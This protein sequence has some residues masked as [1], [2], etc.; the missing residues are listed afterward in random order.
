LPTLAQQ[1]HR[2]AQRLAMQTTQ[3]AACN[4]L[5]EVEERL[6][7][8]ILMTHDRVPSD[9]LPLTQE[10]MAQMLGSRRASVTIAAGLLQKGGLISY[11][12][13]SVRIL[14]RRKLEQASCE[15][16]G[17]VQKQLSDWENGA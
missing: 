14:D 1:L 3:I 7:R 10:F 11:S 4:R 17:I 15:C 13:G 2:F 6:A 8:W 12:R 5:H 9:N 16:Y